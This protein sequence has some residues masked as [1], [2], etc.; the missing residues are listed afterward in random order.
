MLNL[1]S[2]WQMLSAKEAV[3]QTCFSVPKYS[4][5]CGR[6]WEG[7][8][9]T[10]LFP[11]HMWRAPSARSV[12]SRRQHL[13][14]EQKLMMATAVKAAGSLLQQRRCEVDWLYVKML[15]QNVEKWMTHR[16]AL[17]MNQSLQKWVA[18]RFFE[19]PKTDLI[20]R[21]SGNL[22][23][24]SA[25]PL[26]VLLLL[27]CHTK[28]FQPMFCTGRAYLEA[29]EEK[30][31]TSLTQRWLFWRNQKQ[32]DNQATFWTG[33]IL[34]YPFWEDLTNLFPGLCVKFVP[35]LTQKKDTTNLGRNF[36]YEDPR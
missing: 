20:W 13:E 23:H 31:N 7:G 29:S 14:T 25:L 27:R 28:G 24:V 36:T 17:Y 10:P 16:F 32:E 1:I 35:K 4:I 6:E 19:T 33:V 21:D 30:Q 22:M 5:F 18:D 9:R 8:C 3:C 26:P 2:L 12:C 15:H 11:G 34:N